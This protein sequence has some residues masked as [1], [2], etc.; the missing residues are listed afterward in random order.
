MIWCDWSEGKIMK[1]DRAIEIE[2]NGNTHKADE[3]RTQLTLYV[4]TYRN[5]HGGYRLIYLA[6]EEL[7]QQSDCAKVDSRRVECLATK[8]SAQSHG[9]RP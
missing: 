5:L 7:M 8:R 1:C 3:G 6:E 4:P 9:R 2:I